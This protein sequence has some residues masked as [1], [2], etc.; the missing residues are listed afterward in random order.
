MSNEKVLL[1]T[2][3]MSELMGSKII[4]NFLSW[5]YVVLIMLLNYNG[6]ICFMTKFTHHFFFQLK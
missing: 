3:N 6:E 1:S 2:Q 5:T 4:K